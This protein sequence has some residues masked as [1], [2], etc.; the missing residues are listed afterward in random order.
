MRRNGGVL[1]AQ[2]FRAYEVRLREQVRSRYR[3]YVIHGFPP[4]S[5]GGVHVAQILKMLKGSD[6]GAAGG[7]TIITQIV[8]GLVRRLDLGWSLKRSLRAPR[9]HHQWRP[10]VVRYE[11]GIDAAVLRALQARGHVL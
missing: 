11:S 4:P 1:S 6:L 2:D 5:S 9:R 3:D 7:P 10:D 8:L